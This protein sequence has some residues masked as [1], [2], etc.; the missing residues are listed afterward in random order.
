MNPE[1]GCK[2]RDLPNL[3]SGKVRLKLQ[4]TVQRDQGIVSPS[5]CILF[6]LIVRSVFIFCKCFSRLGDMKKEVSNF[7]EEDD[8]GAGLGFQA[9]RMINSLSS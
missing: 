5:V 2:F 6:E 9:I 1:F 4:L 3:E 8:Q 7:V